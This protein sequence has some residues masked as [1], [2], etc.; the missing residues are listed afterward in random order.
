MFPGTIALGR[1]TLAAGLAAVSCSGPQPDVTTAVV[2]NPATG[3]SAA[4]KNSHWVRTFRYTTIDASKSSVGA[5][6]TFESKTPYDVL[7]WARFNRMV[8]VGTG[9]ADIESFQI[10]VSG[11]THPVQVGEEEIGDA[12]HGVMPLKEA[13]D[14]TLE[15]MTNEDYI[16]EVYS[17]SNPN[18]P[19]AEDPPNPK[20]KPDEMQDFTDEQNLQN[21]D[22]PA[23]KMKLDKHVDNVIKSAQITPSVTPPSH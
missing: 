2:K 20:P 9:G 16:I 14:C 17:P 8:S 12:K 19:P 15:T 23:E 21:Q 13:G 10:L 6:P 5:R 4:N 7:C 22:W 11:L 1:L 3:M 18:A